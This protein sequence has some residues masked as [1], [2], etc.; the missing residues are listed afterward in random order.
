MVPG[1][2]PQQAVE[3]QVQMP[4]PN[5]AIRFPAPEAE[6]PPPQ[7]GSRLN[8]NAPVFRP[9]WL[10]SASSDASSIVAPPPALVKSEAKAAASGSRGKLRGK[11][12]KMS[13][14]DFLG[15][16]GSAPTH[17]EMFDTGLQSGRYQRS[18]SVGA[19]STDQDKRRGGWSNKYEYA[20]AGQ[21]AAYE[22]HVHRNRHGHAI[23][24][25]VKPGYRAGA[26]Q[27][28]KTEEIHLDD[29]EATYKIPRHD[30]HNK[31]DDGAGGS[32]TSVV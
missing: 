31:P 26:V 20:D 8:P 18:G 6:P 15:S 9:P 27:G 5:R 4:E 28:G 7:Q 13:L 24:A 1:P 2:Q 17:R 23:M 14:G 11:P 29:L 22:I 30:P 21:Q 12:K 19:Y 25:H 16:E 10:K 3:A 32:S